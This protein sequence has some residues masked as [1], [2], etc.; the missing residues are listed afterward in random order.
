MKIKQWAAV[1]ACTAALS[2][3]AMALTVMPG[4]EMASG[5]ETSQAQIDDIVLALTG[6]GDECYKDNVGGSESGP[7]A[8]SYQTE[9][10]N[11]PTDP[12]D[13]TITYMGGAVAAPEVFLLVKDG[14]QDPAW[15]LFNLTSMGWNGTDTLELNE[16]WPNQGAISHVAL[17]CETGHGV[18]DVGATFSLLG[19]SLLGLA[20]F[21]RRR[22]QKA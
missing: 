9:Y 7:L 16:F 19:S 13:A 11:S 14:N 10:F 22:E 8:G 4:D 6:Y 17:Y 18:P 12:K 15:Y 20:W 3:N 2:M 5:P 1:V 21:A